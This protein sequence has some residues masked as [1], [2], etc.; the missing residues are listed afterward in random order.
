MQCT[1]E[2]AVMLRSSAKTALEDFTKKVTTML[3]DATKADVPND[4]KL[5]LQKTLQIIQQV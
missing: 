1:D 2:K 5:H 4:K 3:S